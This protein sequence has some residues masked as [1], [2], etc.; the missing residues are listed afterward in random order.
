[1]RLASSFSPKKMACHARASLSSTSFHDHRISQDTVP[2]TM[3]SPVGS[4]RGFFSIFGSRLRQCLNNGSRVGVLRL[5]SRL[6]EKAF[7][8]FI[9][10]EI[11]RYFVYNSL[12]LNVIVIDLNELVLNASSDE[13]V[14]SPAIRY[15]TSFPRALSMNQPLLRRKRPLRKVLILRIRPGCPFGIMGVG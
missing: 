10:S 15:T 3:Y 1:L 12:S 8:V 14:G 2:R 5:L 6:V 13:H 4:V 9:T 11:S 7:R